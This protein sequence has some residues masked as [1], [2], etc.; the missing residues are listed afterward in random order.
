MVSEYIDCRELNKISDILDSVIENKRHEYWQKWQ[1]S[2]TVFLSLYSENPAV[3]C[4]GD[5]Y[6]DIDSGMEEKASIERSIFSLLDDAI[7]YH[8]KGASGSASDMKMTAKNL[9]AIARHADMLAD[10]AEKILKE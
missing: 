2:G 3:C 10:K 5:D 6:M 8:V 9:R 7:P 4:L 1:S